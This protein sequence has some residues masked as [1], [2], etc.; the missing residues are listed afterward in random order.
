MSIKIS[1]KNALKTFFGVENPS[2]DVLGFPLKQNDENRISAL[3]SQNFFSDGAKAKVTNIGAYTYDNVEG[4]ITVDANAAWLSA[5]SDNVSLSLNDVVL[6]DSD[7]T[8]SDTHNGSYKI[9][10]L[11]GVSSQ[12]VFTR[13]E[14]A[15]ESSDFLINKTIRVLEGDVNGGREFAITSDSNPV[16]GTDDIVFEYKPGGDVGNNSVG[17]EQLQDDAVSTDK[18]QDDSVNIDKVSASIEASLGKADSALQADD[19]TGKQDTLITG[20]FLEIGSVNDVAITITSNDGAVTD[21]DLLGSSSGSSWGRIDINNFPNIRFSESFTIGEIYSFEDGSGDIWKF[22]LGSINGGGLTQ[23][24]IQLIPA[25]EPIVI[26]G[27]SQS[28]GHL[29]DFVDINGTW[30]GSGNI[31][32]TGDDG[33][34]DVKAGSIDEGSSSKVVSAE[35]LKTEFAKKADSFFNGYN[36]TGSS[37]G[38]S[39][40]VYISGENGGSGN[41]EISLADNDSLSSSMVLGFLESEI[42]DSASGIVRTHGTMAN[43]NTSSANA[44]DSAYLGDDG[45]IVFSKPEGSKFILKIGV[46]TKSHSSTGEI[47]FIGGLRVNDLPNLPNGYMWRGN[48]NG[49]PEAVQSDVYTAPTALNFTSSST[50][51]GTAGSE[52]VYQAT[53]DGGKCLFDLVDTD[54]TGFEIDDLSGDLYGTN[55]AAGTYDIEVYAL[56]IRTGAKKNFTVT[57]TIS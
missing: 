53:T 51:S 25:T 47:I 19:I 1:I 42:A 35:D 30:D 44:G 55:P 31:I 14:N 41:P 24:Y 2:G 34:I 16:I 21:G 50:A 15:D 5:D 23:T 18:I 20:D 40:L 17:E 10:D 12:V 33:V 4:T 54:S 37:I 57:F 9:T 38:A 6:F 52:V 48:S 49:V 36:N 28:T 13:S 8:S 39:K 43:L 26:S 45:D 56:S 29:Q 22:E 27:Q 7:T 3:E 46:V 32:K 11:G